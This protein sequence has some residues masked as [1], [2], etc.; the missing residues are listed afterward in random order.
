MGGRRYCRASQPEPGGAAPSPCMEAATQ[1]HGLHERQAAT[2]ALLGRACIRYIGSHGRSAPPPLLAAACMPHP[3]PRSGAQQAVNRGR[4]LELGGDGV[5]GLL[6]CRPGRGGVREPLARQQ[7][8]A[9]NTCTAGHAANRPRAGQ[10]C[11]RRAPTMEVL[12]CYGVHVPALLGIAPP[13]SLGAGR[14]KGAARAVCLAEGGAGAH[15]G[16]HVRWD[17]ARQGQRMHA[18]RPAREARRRPVHEAGRPPC[19]DNP[20]LLS[21]CQPHLKLDNLNCH[22]PP[23]RSRRAPARH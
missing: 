21:L 3:K 19:T 11:P 16:G 10:P 1:R 22:H 5:C 9:A 4:L 7:G 18:G 14:H 12:A 17:P 20:P 23:A 2:G 13:G 15:R 8:V 6:G